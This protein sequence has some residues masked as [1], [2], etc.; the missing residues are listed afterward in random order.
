MLAH[1]FLNLNEDELRTF[2]TKAKAVGLDAME[3]IYSTYDDETTRIS[4]KIAEEFGLN[5]SGGS[6][7]HGSR[8]PNISLGVGRGNLRVPSA[9][10]EQLKLLRNDKI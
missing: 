5:Q 6:D 9:F 8:K 2:L 3:T 1:P 10:V 7:F 4:I